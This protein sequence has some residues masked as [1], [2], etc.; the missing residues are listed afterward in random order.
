MDAA[1]RDGM[2]VR[3]RAELRT[4]LGRLRGLKG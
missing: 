4:D 3:L 2:A 1:E